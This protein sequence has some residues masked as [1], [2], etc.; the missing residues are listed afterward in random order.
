M[1]AGK[2]VSGSKV[3][4]A[5][6][7]VLGVLAGCDE[8]GTA[9]GN[10]DVQATPSS[11]SSAP[12]GLDGGSATGPAGTAQQAIQELLAVSP[13]SFEPESSELTPEA[14]A[15]VKTIAEAVA[16]AEDVKLSVTTRSGYP[17]PDEATQ[18]SQERAEAIKAELAA[19]GVAE[20][21]VEID[22]RGNEKS[23]AGDYAVEITVI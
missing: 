23:D 22:P 19:N 21:S 11:S 1:A 17:D 8:G 3:I 4:A 2:L 7:L 20:D 16:A 18:A 10:R 5:A 9:G 14:K 15:T 12:V 13:I 6:A